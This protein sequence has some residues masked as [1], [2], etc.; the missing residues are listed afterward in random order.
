MSWT[1]IQ[2]WSKAAAGWAA[3]ALVVQKLV[4][5]E[6]QERATAIIAEEI[7][8]RLAMMDYPSVPEPKNSN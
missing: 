7:H 5:P 4:A 3:H 6:E 8:A 2:A 1:E